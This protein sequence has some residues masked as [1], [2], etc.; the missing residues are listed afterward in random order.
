MLSVLFC[1]CKWYDKHKT[2]FHLVMP[3]HEQRRPLHRDFPHFPGWMWPSL[4]YPPAASF[5]LLLLQR[6]F[7]IPRFDKA[8]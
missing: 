8:E 1:R 4:L 5:L 6:R 3:K 2:G 7:N